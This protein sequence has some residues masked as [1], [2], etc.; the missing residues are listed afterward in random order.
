MNE[1]IEMHGQQN[2]KKKKDYLLVKNVLHVSAYKG[3]FCIC[4]KKK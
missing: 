2:I 4:V 1:Y 3:T